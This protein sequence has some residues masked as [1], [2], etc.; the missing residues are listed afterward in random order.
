L[1]RSKPADAAGAGREARE[2]AQR[3]VG[4][5]AS[6]CAHVSGGPDARMP[7]LLLHRKKKVGSTDL[8]SVLQVGGLVH[9]QTRLT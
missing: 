5:R 3:H 7:L 2:Q 1:G 6:G 9:C 8:K 4:A